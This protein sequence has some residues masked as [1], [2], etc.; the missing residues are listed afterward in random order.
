MFKIESKMTHSTVLRFDRVPG[1]DD[2]CSRVPDGG[3][4]DVL[5]SDIDVQDACYSLYTYT[6]PN[7]YCI[8]NAGTTLLVDLESGDK[9]YLQGL[10]ERIVVAAQADGW[11]VD[12]A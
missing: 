9:D 5:F 7:S 11:G 2:L 1:P 4:L 12:R 3:A 8:I 6:P 10:C